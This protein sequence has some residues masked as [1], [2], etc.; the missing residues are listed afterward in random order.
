MLILLLPLQQ[1]LFQDFRQHPDQAI[2]VA[3]AKLFRDID[4]ESGE[5]YHDPRSVLEAVCRRF[6]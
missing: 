6:A 4:S 5:R 1:S 2:S 3:L